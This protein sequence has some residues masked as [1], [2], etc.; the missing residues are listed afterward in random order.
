MAVHTSSRSRHTPPG[1]AALELHRLAV[2]VAALSET[3]LLDKGELE[4]G[5]YHFLYSGN[6]LGEERQHR[7]AIAIRSKLRA[8]VQHWHAVNARIVTARINLRKERSLMVISAYAP[9]LTRP[10]ESKSI[11]YEDLENV[12]A[13]VDPRD[14]VILLDFNARVGKDYSVWP[15]VIG[16]HGLGMMNDNGRLLAELC[17]Q[18]NLTITNTCFRHKAIHLCTWQHPQSKMWH[19]IDHIIVRRSQL[20]QVK[21]TR[22]FT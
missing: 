16:H 20:G 9:T 8:S 1:R 21:N 22:V 15:S 10:E 2:D 6:P 18:H 7:V 5:G 14:F 12:I 3:R 4:K 19:M 13:Q 11:F 17:T